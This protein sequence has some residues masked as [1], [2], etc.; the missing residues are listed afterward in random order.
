MRVHTS[1]SE[2]LE[3]EANELDIQSIE[4]V[5]GSRASY[6]MDTPIDFLDLIDAIPF[7]TFLSMFSYA[8]E[9]TSTIQANIAVELVRAHLFI[10]TNG[11]APVTRLL[12]YADEVLRN[13]PVISEQRLDYCQDPIPGSGQADWKA[14]LA[15]QANILQAV[16][17]ALD[18]SVPYIPTYSYWMISP[19][20]WTPDKIAAY[21]DPSNRWEVSATQTDS[22][23][24]TD[25]V[26]PSSYN[27]T[28]LIDTLLEMD[29]DAWLKQ[30]TTWDSQGSTNYGLLLVVNI[31][32]QRG[33][34][35]PNTG[36]EAIRAIGNAALVAARGVSMSIPSLNSVAGLLRSARALYAAQKRLETQGRIGRMTE[37]S[38]FGVFPNS[39]MSGDPYLDSAEK[40]VESAGE[41]RRVQLMR[42][43]A[44]IRSQDKDLDGKIN[45]S[46]RKEMEIAIRK[47]IREARAT[48]AQMFLDETLNKFN[49]YQ[50]EDSEKPI[51]DIIKPYLM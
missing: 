32:H 28:Q 1:Y 5:I 36:V 6:G 33:N 49:S 31:N 13:D 3:A 42:D 48:T 21:V 37:L 27:P 34:E 41:A 2:L 7:D 14:R 25:P 22:A 43:P 9:D 38:R 17:D 12:D 10:W 16:V 8:F 40:V 18:S 4:R 15:S 20:P 44:W 39:T 19:S 46:D 26:I 45:A 51:V 30:S 47:E 23:S 35:Q 11:D 50:L 29:P 24:A